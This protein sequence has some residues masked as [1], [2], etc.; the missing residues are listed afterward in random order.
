MGHDHSYPGTEVQ[1]QR[2][3]CSFLLKICIFYLFIVQLLRVLPPD[4]HQSSTPGSLWSLCAR[5]NE[6][7]AFGGMTTL[8]GKIVVQF[9]HVTFV[10]R[11][12]NAI[13]SLTR[14]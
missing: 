2:S 4:P 6:F 13:D 12:V 3:P 11:N 5:E 7:W 1:G 8:V 10:K 14:H 9:M